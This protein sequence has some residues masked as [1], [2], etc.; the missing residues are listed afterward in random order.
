MAIIAG[1]WVPGALVDFGGLHFIVNLEGGL[2][3]VCSSD[4]SPDIDGTDFVIN[5]L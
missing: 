2:E 4:S 3:R 1:D 5:S